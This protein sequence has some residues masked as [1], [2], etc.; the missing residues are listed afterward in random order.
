MTINNI[1]KIIDRFEGSGTFVY[2]TPLVLYNIH[3]IV[4]NFDWSTYVINYKNARI[5]F[6]T[7][8]LFYIIPVQ[9]SETV[10]PG[11]LNVDY[12]IVDG[13]YWGYMRPGKVDTYDILSIENIGSI[14]INPKVVGGRV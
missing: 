10:P 5:V 8:G 2:D 14:I 6:K 7:T 3:S 9:K 4:N 12:D 13:E 11:T 1:Q